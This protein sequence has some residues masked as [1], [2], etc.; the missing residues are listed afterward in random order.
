V[1]LGR[2]EGDV[3]LLPYPAKRLLFAVMASELLHGSPHPASLEVRNGSRP[4][5]PTTALLPV[6]V[7]VPGEVEIPEPAG[8]QQPAASGSIHIEFPGR[9]MISV[10]SGAD[11]AF[12][13]RTVLARIAEH[14][15][16]RIQELLP[17]NIAASLQTDSAQAA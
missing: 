13:L 17:W 6:T 10:E 14:P 1:L 7:A 8:Q 4:V 5:A 15:I 12:Y 2:K 3:S 11:P 16:N 9:A